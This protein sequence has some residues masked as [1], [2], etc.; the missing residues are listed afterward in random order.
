MPPTLRKWRQRSMRAPIA[1]S[2]FEL[3][4]KIGAKL[5]ALPGNPLSF[6][7]VPP[8]SDAAFPLIHFQPEHSPI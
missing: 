7:M 6:L 4:V 2:E 3:A 5:R 1:N 8:E